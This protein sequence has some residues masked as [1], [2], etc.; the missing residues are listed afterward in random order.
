MSVG[1]YLACVAGWRSALTDE[2]VEIESLR[3]SN[4]D[5]VVGWR[6]ERDVSQ[7]RNDV[8]GKDRLHETG[9]T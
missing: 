2:F 6:R 8:V 9:A 3:A 4:L 1:N 5:R 7:R